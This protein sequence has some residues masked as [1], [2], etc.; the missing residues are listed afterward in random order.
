MAMSQI[1]FVSAVPL[2]I[3]PLELKIQICG[4]DKDID[5]HV[6]VMMSPLMASVGFKIN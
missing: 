6:F 2:E 5:M 4:F 1:Y 3:F